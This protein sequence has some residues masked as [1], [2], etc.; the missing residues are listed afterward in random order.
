MSPDGFDNKRD[1]NA[2][3]HPEKDLKPGVSKQFRKL[4]LGKMMLF[5]K[6]L[7]DL[8]QDPRLLTCSAP[9]AL[10]IEHHDDGKGES[11]GEDR[12]VKSVI[13]SDGGRERAD[14]GRMRA[15][16][17]ARADEIA[18]IE[19]VCFSPGQGHLNGLCSG[20]CQKTCPDRCVMGEL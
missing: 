1:Q 19:V 20:P 3:E 13:Y 14:G 5:E 16:H 8:V 2:E 11:D 9:H 17:A 10:R 4:V 7:N 12:G 6:L 18:E 15:G